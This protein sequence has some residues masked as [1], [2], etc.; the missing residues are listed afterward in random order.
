MQEYTDLIENHGSLV[1][2]KSI[3]DIVRGG[4]NTLIQQQTF[5]GL[6]EPD[7]PLD[8]D[9]DEDE[10]DDRVQILED[11]LLCLF[12]NE[13]SLKKRKHHDP[14]RPTRKKRKAFKHGDRKLYSTNPDT[15]ERQLYSFEYS[16]W[17]ASYIQNPRPDNPN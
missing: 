3:D 12:T 11:E 2:N 4:S 14:H 17:Y 6:N 5:F 15:N 1:P 8:S 9:D 7:F 16:L 13:H 10:F